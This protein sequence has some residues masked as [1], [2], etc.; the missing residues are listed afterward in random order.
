MKVVVSFSIIKDDGR[1]FT[2]G[3][4]DMSTFDHERIQ[5]EVAALGREIAKYVAL[6]KLESHGYLSDDA[7]PQ[8][9]P[10]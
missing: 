1:P 4:N 6:A 7:G 3:E 9:A 5:S 10:M 2:S 8:E